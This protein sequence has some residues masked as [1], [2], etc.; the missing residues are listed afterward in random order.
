M[1]TVN[2]TIRTATV[3]D[4]GV[5]GDLAKE[6]QVYLRGLGD[7]TQFEFTAETYRRDGFGLHAAF[8]VSSLNL[9]AK[10]SV[11]S[12]ITSATIRIGQGG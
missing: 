1:S 2:A 5:I 11:I 6:F 3:D 7:R 9:M 12:C 8:A 4:A 10:W